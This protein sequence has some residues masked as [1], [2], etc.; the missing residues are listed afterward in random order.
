MHR[1][2][3]QVSGSSSL[4][5]VCCSSCV[6]SG[7][8]R[9]EIGDVAV[10]PL[11]SGCAFVVAA[12]MAFWAFRSRKAPHDQHLLTLA[13]RGRVGEPSTRVY[14]VRLINSFRLLPPFG[15]SSRTSPTP[16]Q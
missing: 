13:P 10:P 1:G 16:A 7:V 14:G 12:A 9:S 2:Y 15:V 6:S 3:A 11:A 5:S 4:W 8:G